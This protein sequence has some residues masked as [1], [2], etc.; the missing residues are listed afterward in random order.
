MAENGR[1]IPTAAEW[2]AVM[3]ALRAAEEATP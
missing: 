3:A 1:L 2:D